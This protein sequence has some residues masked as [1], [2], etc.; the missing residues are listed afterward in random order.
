MAAMWSGGRNPVSVRCRVFLAV[1]RALPTSRAVLPCGE[2]S[3]HQGG[4]LNQPQ[5]RRCARKTHEQFQLNSCAAR[6]S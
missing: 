5:R 1:V 3:Q 2:N 4:A 6:Q